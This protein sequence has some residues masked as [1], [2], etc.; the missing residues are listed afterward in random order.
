VGVMKALI[1]TLKTRSAPETRP[2]MLNGKM[3]RAII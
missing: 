1:D 2:G 3:M